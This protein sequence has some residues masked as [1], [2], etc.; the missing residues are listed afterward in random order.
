MEQGECLGVGGTGD[1]VVV[2][3]VIELKP[4]KPDVVEKDIPAQLD[5]TDRRTISPMDVSVAN[6][7]PSGGVRSMLAKF[8]NKQ[9]ISVELG[10]RLK[11]KLM[12][13]IQ[14]KQTKTVTL[15]IYFHYN[16]SCFCLKHS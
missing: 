4:V 8:E 7:L 2:E 11:V 10:P 3:P 15:K 16:A 1:V 9:T 13:N 14:E 5:A 12:N 6:M